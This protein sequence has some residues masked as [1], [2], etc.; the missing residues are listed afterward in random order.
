MAHF[1]S[2]IA[3]GIPTKPP[4]NSKTPL[5]GFCVWSTGTAMAPST[6]RSS[7]RSVY[8][9]LRV[10]LFMKVP[11]MSQPLRTFG[12][13]PT[14]M[15]ITL[16][17]NGPFGLTAVPSR[18]VGMICTVLTLA[19][20]VFSTGAKEPLPL[21]V[22]CLAMVKDSSRVLLISIEPAP[23]GVNWKWLSLEE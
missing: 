2:R 14:G 10:S 23:T 8:L 21:R 5:T 13:S 17:M 4:S 1:M 16:Q 22:M 20:T 19:R 15:A 11:S 7:L 9:S 18:A 12:S 3:Q 6:N